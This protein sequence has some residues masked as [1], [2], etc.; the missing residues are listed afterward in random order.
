MLISPWYSLEL[1]I[2]MGI[3]FLFSAICKT[4]SDN[5]FTFLHFFFLG[6]VLITAPSSSGTLS[7]LIP[8]TYLSLPLYNHKG[9]DLSHTWIVYSGF[10]YFLQYKSDNNLA[11][12]S[13]WSEP[14]SAPGLIF[15][16][17]TVSIYLA[18]K[19]VISGLAKKFV[20]VFCSSS[21]KNSSVL[22]NTTVSGLLW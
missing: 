14:Q 13:S 10:P 16:D 7:D 15:A 2:Q 21:L 11:I 4:S 5:H 20:W 17:Y 22:A 9:F 18:A 19:N 6:M 12:R 8:W 3:S 1:C